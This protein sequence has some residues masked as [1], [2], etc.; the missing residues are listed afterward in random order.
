MD[1]SIARGRGG[2]GE[3]VVGL[4]ETRPGALAS[5]LKQAD[6]MAGQSF[7]DVGRM[8]EE[9]VVRSKDRQGKM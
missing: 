4:E 9:G 2:E 6:D 3:V 5:T 1:C 8:D 7:N